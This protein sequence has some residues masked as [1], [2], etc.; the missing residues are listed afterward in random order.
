MT[1]K[2]AKYIFL[3]FYVFAVF[4]IAGC[5]T[6]KAPP[7]PDLEWVPPKWEKTIKKPDKVWNLIRE[8]EITD[9]EPLTLAELV[10]M[11]FANNPVIRNAWQKARAREAEVKQ[12]QSEYYPQG[13]V[14]GDIT[15]QKKVA[16]RKI[17]DSNNYNYSPKAVITYMILDLGGRD[18]SVRQATQEVISANFTFNRT[19]QD[20]LFDTAKAYYSFYSAQSDLKAKKANVEDASTALEAA[21]IKFSTGLA[22][23]LDVLQAK[24]N[25]EDTLYSLEDAK[26]TVFTTKGD[27]AETVGFAPDLDFEITAPDENVPLNI[28]SENVSMLI[29]SALKERPDIGAARAVL[30]SKEEAVKVANSDLWPTLNITGS[31]EKRWYRFFGDEETNW[32]YYDCSGYF[33]VNW[34]IF[35]GF[36]KYSKRRQA[37]AELDAER[38]QLKQ[39]ELNAASDVWTKYYN[40]KTAVKKL[41]FSKSF[42][43]T[44]QASHDLA[45]EGYKSGIKSILDLLEAQSQLQ[46]ARS[47]L[48]ESQKDLFVSSAG[49]ARAMGTLSAKD[50]K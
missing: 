3:F 6:L 34:D 21:S 36:Y 1:K 33:S 8:E 44:A 43:E 26:G 45:L 20:L 12:A 25:Y 40:L 32:Q 23:K 37:Q 49:L 18:A 42:L 24:S 13:T 28:T 11:A 9:Q 50:L 30:Y 35:D 27:L 47:K 41:V 14:S 29:E 16:T 48:V 17:E 2:T 7:K 10:D 4:F 15:R 19:I 38:E 22:S 5:Q 39:T 46:E 31:A